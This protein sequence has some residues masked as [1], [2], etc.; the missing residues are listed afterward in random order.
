MAKSDLKRQWEPNE[1]A[2]QRLLSWLDQGSDSE[3][4]RYLELRE[5]LVL[6]FAHRNGPAPEDLA[7]ETLNRVAR[8]LEETGSIDDIV[9]ARYCYIVAKF[10][11]LEALRQRRRQLNVSSGDHEVTTQPRIIDEAAAEHERAV[12]CLEQCLAECAAS[13]RQLILDYYRTE[14]GSA[15]AQRKQLAGWLGL[16]ANSLA[17]RAC[18]IRSQLERCVRLCRQR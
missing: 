17:I 4:Q 5:R 16:T 18:R 15:S 6:Y 2:F 12:T 1:G 8:R 7:D 9:P 14:S 13:D 11:L 3:G 10:V